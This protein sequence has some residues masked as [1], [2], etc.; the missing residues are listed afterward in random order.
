MNSFAGVPF[1]KRVSVLQRPF[2][3]VPVASFV[4][5]VFP[6]LP[7]YGRGGRRRGKVRST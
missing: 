6:V 2:T 4:A 7:Q 5:V 3:V 1:Q